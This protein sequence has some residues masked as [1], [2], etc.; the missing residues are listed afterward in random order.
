MTSSLGTF[1]IVLPLCI[2]AGFL[3]AAVYSLIY[4]QRSTSWVSTEGE[5]VVSALK[6]TRDPDSGTASV[7]VKIHYKYK[8]GN[9]TYTSDT[10]K[11]G[12]TSLFSDMKIAAKYPRGKRVRVY[13]D[14]N[15]P[16]R[17]TLET[18]VSVITIMAYSIIGVL[19]LTL[20]FLLGL[21]E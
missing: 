18:G 16:K 20:P 7:T 6:E 17:S 4:G 3:I 11:I 15:N 21:G 9:E 14:P 5:V 12:G 10:V 19:F 13:Y 2:G 8:V 1:D